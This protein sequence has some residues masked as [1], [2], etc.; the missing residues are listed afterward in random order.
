MGSIEGN[1]LKLNFSSFCFLR[2]KCHP[3][4]T[5]SSNVGLRAKWCPY[6]HPSLLKSTVKA[7]EGWRTF[8]VMQIRR[9]A[10]LFT[11]RWVTW[12]NLLMLLPTG[13]YL[14]PGGQLSG[15]FIVKGLLVVCYLSSNS[16]AIGILL[17]PCLLPLRHE[18]IILSRGITQLTETFHVRTRVSKQLRP[19]TVLM[20]INEDSVSF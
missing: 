6:P 20:S 14:R 15:L 17:V 19:S 3:I 2:E 1:T 10:E 8:I 7:D 18:F 11:G 12:W 13:L 9:R 4:N 16:W 5:F